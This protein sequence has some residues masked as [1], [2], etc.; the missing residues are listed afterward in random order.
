MSKKEKSKVNKFKMLLNFFKINSLLM[1]LV[2]FI[3]ALVT[4]RGN[5]I[6]NIVLTVIYFIYMVITIVG[7]LKNDK[8]VKKV[9]KKG[10][11]W[12]KML[13]K[14]FTLASTLYGIYTATTDVTFVSVLMAVFMTSFYL[15]KLFFSLMVEIISHKVKKVAG[16][17]KNKNKDEVEVR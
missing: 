12:A 8:S 6:I 16:I 4:E 14:L 15:M 7:I 9:A 13:I 2:Y 11:K 3:Y 1:T 17:F 10:Y 5:D